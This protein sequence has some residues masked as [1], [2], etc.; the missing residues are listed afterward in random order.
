MKLLFLLPALLL[1]G[2]VSIELPHLVEDTAKV[3]KSAYQALTKRDAKPAASGISHSYLGNSA[4]TTIEIK[5]HCETE[6]ARKLRQMDSELRYTVLENEI[7]VVYG[8][9]AANCRLAPLL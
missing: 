9:I 5:Q 2:C 4:Q 1:S 3:S 8:N 6:A 7:V